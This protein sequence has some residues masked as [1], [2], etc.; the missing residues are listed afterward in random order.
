MAE[1][2]KKILLTSN[3]KKHFINASEILLVKARNIY[4]II[5]LQ[6]GDELLVNETISYIE[7]QLNSPDFYRAH[8]SYLVN[9]HC[10]ITY[11]KAK[12]QLVIKNYN[13]LTPIARDKKKDFELVLNTMFKAITK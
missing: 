7:K 12:Q 13:H 5:Y 10:I 4:A 9:I 3:K 6:N 11:H 8:R 1:P 2:I